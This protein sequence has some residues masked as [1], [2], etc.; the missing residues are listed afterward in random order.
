MLLLASGVLASSCNVL[1]QEQD[2]YDIAWD[3]V[4]ASQSW[5]ATL[6]PIPVSAA[7]EE[8]YYAIPSYSPFNTTIADPEFLKKY[9]AMVSRAYF[10]LIAEA[11][12]ADQR[13]ARSYQDIYR[14][15]HMPGAEGNSILQ[16][17]YELADKRFL[18]HRDMLDGLRSWN[19]FNDYGSDDLDF[20]MQEQLPVAYDKYER[21]VQEDELIDY[22]MRGLADLYHKK[23]G[24]LEPN[25][26]LPG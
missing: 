22:L 15:A 18:A 24:G 6:D 25:E 9:P 16:R 8:V 5:K 3:D 20:F 7:G 12:D 4:V 26:L 23:Y 2:P 21:G 14:R 1:K 13:I 17:E 10:R 11:M 19:A